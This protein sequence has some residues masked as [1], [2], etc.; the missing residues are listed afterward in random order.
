MGEYVNSHQMRFD[1]STV[2]CGLL[3]A[4]HIPKG[5][6]TKNVFAIATALYHKANPRPSAF[7]QFSDVVDS[8]D[9]RGVKLAEKIKELF[10]AKGS[11]GLWESPI[12]VNPRSGNRI[13]IWVW[14]LDH[15]TIRKWYQE[16]LANNVDE[17]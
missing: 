7:V 9:Q 4:H 3:C 15:E 17:D 6:A 16:E 13:R 5:S 10:P 1:R 14:S 8:E 2:S 12:H 11:Y